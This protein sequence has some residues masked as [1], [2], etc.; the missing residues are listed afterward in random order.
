MTLEVHHK[1]IDRAN[2][3]SNA[4]VLCSRCHAATPPYG[5]REDHRSPYRDPSL[6]QLK[7]PPLV[8]RRTN[9]S[10]HESVAVTDIA[11]IYPPPLSCNCTKWDA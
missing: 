10:A 2:T 8:A 9:V 5:A 3:L 7:T 4:K 1:R 11:E 6:R